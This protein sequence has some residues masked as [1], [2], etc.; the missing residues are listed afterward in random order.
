MTR[1]SGFA[2]ITFLAVKIANSLSKVA[3]YLVDLLRIFRLSRNIAVSFTVFLGQRE[4]PTNLIPL[5]HIVSVDSAESPESGNRF[6]ASI[7]LTNELR[8]TTRN[9]HHGTYIVE[10]AKSNSS[11]LESLR[12]IWCLIQ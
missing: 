4:L 1:I 2:N 5:V 11:R 12:G 9:E 3:I 10:E 7:V 6:R 8:F